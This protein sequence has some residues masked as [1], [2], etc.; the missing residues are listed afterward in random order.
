MESAETPQDAPRTVQPAEGTG[1]Q[2]EDRLARRDLVLLRLEAGR[3]HGMRRSR[4]LTTMPWPGVP[5]QAGVVEAEVLTS[6][7]DLTA[8]ASLPS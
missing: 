1:P 4:A 3:R 2:M 7:R 6:D 5:A 8:P